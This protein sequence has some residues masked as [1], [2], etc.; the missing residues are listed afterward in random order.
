MI[1]GLMTGIFSIGFV[2][3][4]TIFVIVHSS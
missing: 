3:Y 2:L 4:L 1:V